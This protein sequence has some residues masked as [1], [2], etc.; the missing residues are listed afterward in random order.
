MVS[1]EPLAALVEQVN[2][3]I[4]GGADPAAET[5]RALA[6]TTDVLAL[7]AM[8]DDLRRARHGQAAT[9]A[10]VHD[11]ELAD[12]DAWTA[13]PAAA[14]EVRLVGHPRSVDEAVTAA[15]RA[16]GLAGGVVLRGF[17]LGDLAA[18]ASADAFRSLRAAGL[19]EVAWAAPGPDA[20]AAVRRAREAGI[21]VRVIAAATPAA[22]R[23]AWLVEAR[24]LVQ[25]VGGFTAVAPLSRQVERASPTTGFDDVRAVS[26]ARL[27]LGD[28]PTVQVDWPRYGPK[29]AQVALTVGADDLDA[30]SPIDDPALGP[31]RAA[32]EDV[33]RNIT[34]AGFTP[35]ERD[36]RWAS[37]AR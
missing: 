8:A 6:G 1:P 30:V 26:L 21:E 3:A 14:S 18:L 28:V 9:Y 35:V 25:A 16:R 2:A 29:L 33:R 24:R 20:A 27:V 19:D 36:G 5:L 17:W 12:I 13:P 32:A 23:L 10:R 31:R 4:A 37:V 22:D 15:S 34:A 7:G 11:L